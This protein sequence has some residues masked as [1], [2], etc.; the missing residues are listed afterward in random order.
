MAI[1]EALLSI[2]NEYDDVLV[3]TPAWGSYRDLVRLCRATP[4]SVRTE[5]SDGYILQPA[6]LAAALEASGPRCRAVVLCN[7]CDPTGAVIPPTILSAL[8]E[9]FQRPE[10]RHVHVVADETFER[11]V[12]DL[13]HVSFA[14]LPG[15][16]SRTLLVGSLS[17]SHGLA[18]HRLGYLVS[19]NEGVIS[20]AVKLQGQITSCASSVSQ[21]VA[22]SAM[23][24]PK[25]VERWAAERT[26]ELRGKRDFVL[27]TLRKINGVECTVPE[28]GCCVLA[29]V[30]GFLGRK[31]SPIKTSDDLCRVL[32]ERKFPVVS[33][34]ALE[35]PSTIRIQYDGPKEQL[36]NLVQSLVELAP[37]RVATTPL[38]SPRRT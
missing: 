25:G 6:A 22:L 21:Q 26:A 11:V 36:E 28:G 24:D 34:E 29:S 27:S 3:P 16:M 2:C 19:A 8:A 10:H 14:S 33:G 23:V 9:V 7:P 31:G 35:A 15:M 30:T 12:Y 17:L 5:A 4:V 37:P 18:G 13:R 1:Y 20:A 38:P 32:S